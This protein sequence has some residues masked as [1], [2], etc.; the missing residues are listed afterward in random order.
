[1]D[2]GKTRY[3]FLRNKLYDYLNKGATLIANKI[4]NE[5]KIYKYRRYFEH[6]SGRPTIASLYLA[7]GNDS[8]F[9]AHWDTRDVFALQFEGRKKWT[10]Y[11]PNFELPI[12]NQES[13]DMKSYSCPDEVY[14]EVI[15]EE[16]DILYIPR[17]WWHDPIPLGET[18]VHLSI[19]TYPFYPRDYIHWLL[20]IIPNHEISIRKDLLSYDQNKDNF[21]SLSEVIHSYLTNNELY[22]IFISQMQ[23][24][25]YRTESPLNLS[26]MASPVSDKIIPDNAKLDINIINN[27]DYN[28]E[29]LIINGVKVNVSLES[30]AI[31]EFLIN[32]PMVEFKKIKTNFQN[33]PVKKLNDFIFELCLTDI[34]ALYL[35]S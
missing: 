5:P 31:F 14:M 19:G 34:L 24:K 18:S 17:G 15:L 16:G 12:N 25:V 35:N 33:I 27:I 4:S 9:R 1:E 20:N 23:D 11:K 7:Y 3:R 26:L 28:W 10:L 8:S 29:Y 2:I 32:N 6:L 22:K 21:D 30:K 13:K